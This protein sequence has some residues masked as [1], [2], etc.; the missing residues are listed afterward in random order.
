M[1]LRIISKCKLGEF[2]FDEACPTAGL[3]IASILQTYQ[4]IHIYTHTYKHTHMY[5]HTCIHLY[6]HKYTTYTHTAYMHISKI[7]TYIHMHTYIHTNTDIQYMHTHMHTHTSLS[8]YLLFVSY[9]SVVSSDE[10]KIIFFFKT[11]Q[12]H[13][14]CWH[15]SFNSSTQEMDTAGLQI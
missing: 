10:S 8:L 1:F 3:L 12:F 5:T 15:M 2:F 9:A 4:H 11:L 6:I 14:M 13:S 7:F